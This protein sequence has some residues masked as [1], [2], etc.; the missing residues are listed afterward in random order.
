LADTSTLHDLRQVEPNAPETHD[1]ND[2]HD[3]V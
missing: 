3:W 2:S 1:L